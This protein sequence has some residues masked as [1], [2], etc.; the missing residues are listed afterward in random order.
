M[1]RFVYR[2]YYQ[3]NG[4]TSSEPF[5]SQKSEQEIIEALTRFPIELPHY[6]SDIE[7]I[8]SSPEPQP[9]SKSSYVTIQTNDNEITTDDAVKKCLNSLDLYGQ[10]LPTA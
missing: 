9:E 10:K 6:L 2:A 8:I 5:R 4:P 7:A 3:Y 1:N